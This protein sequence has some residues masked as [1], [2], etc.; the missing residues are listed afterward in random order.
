MRIFPYLKLLFLF[1]NRFES[2]RLDRDKR[3]RERLKLL[4]RVS[5][6]F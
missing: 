4:Y 3:C 1:R 5:G 2:K 6:T